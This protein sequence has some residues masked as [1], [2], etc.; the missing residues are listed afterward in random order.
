FSSRW[1]GSHRLLNG[2]WQWYTIVT[3]TNGCV[4]QVGACI[5]NGYVMFA[6]E[7]ASYIHRAIMA[8]VSAFQGLD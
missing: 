8:D 4:C 2:Y 5:K 7:V 3:M 1:D 6:N